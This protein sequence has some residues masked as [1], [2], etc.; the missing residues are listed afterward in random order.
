MAYGEIA[1]KV[2]KRLLGEHLV[3]KAKVFVNEHRFA[4]A[5]RDA[6]ALLTAM[7][8]RLQ[9]ERRQTRHVLP[10]R[11]NAEHSARLLGPVRPFP[12]KCRCRH[13]SPIMHR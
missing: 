10:R 5:D 3:D 9:S 2:R 1:F 8:Q 11:I 7:L 6:R 4:I 13:K 12:W